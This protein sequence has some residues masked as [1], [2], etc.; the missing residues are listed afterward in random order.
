MSGAKHGGRGN[1]QSELN[2]QLIG[3]FLLIKFQLDY[4]FSLGQRERMSAFDS[5]PRDL[6]SA[7][8]NVIRMIN[9]SPSNHKEIATKTISWLFRTQIPLT[10]DALL[11]AI[12]VD[13]VDRDLVPDFMD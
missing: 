13:I 3:R 2:T 4:I 1:V 10:M 9:E 8:D 12:S 5:I 6:P 11:E 7:Y